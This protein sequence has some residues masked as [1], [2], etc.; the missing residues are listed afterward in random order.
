MAAQRQQQL[1]QQQSRS[2]T[3]SFDEDMAAALSGAP[4]DSLARILMLRARLCHRKALLLGQHAKGH[5]YRHAFARDRN[6][7]R[8]DAGEWRERW[9]FKG[10]KR[11]AGGR[12]LFGFFPFSLSLSL[13]SMH[14]RT[15]IYLLYIQ[16]VQ[17]DSIR[18]S[19]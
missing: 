2:S 11:P 18:V 13:S 15:H 6:E 4:Q 12:L 9:A 8:N 7:A 10:P 1:R 17:C 19:S 16:K 14:A 5:L 3:D